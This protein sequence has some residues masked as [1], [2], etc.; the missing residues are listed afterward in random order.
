NEVIPR[1]T[2][3]S[4]ERLA[5]KYSES[6]P[7]SLSPSNQENKK[8]KEELAQAMKISKEELKKG[9]KE[10]VQLLEKVLKASL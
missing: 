8:Y 2:T 3:R 6:S 1:R 10:E 9:Y 4:K 5:R 7:A